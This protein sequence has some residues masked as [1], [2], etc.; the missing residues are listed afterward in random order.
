[1]EI[2]KYFKI[3]NKSPFKKSWCIYNYING[4][5]SL[6]RD[7]VKSLTRKQ[8]HSPPFSISCTDFKNAIK[9]KEKL[10]EAAFAEVTRSSK[11]IRKN[12][13]ELFTNLIFCHQVTEFEKTSKISKPSKENYFFSLRNSNCNQKSTFPM[14][15]LSIIATI[16]M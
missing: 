11:S 10:I 7:L 9:I 12:F 8:R 2:R 6:W 3:G 16:M 5:P 4:T 15:F 1:M 14:Y 13:E